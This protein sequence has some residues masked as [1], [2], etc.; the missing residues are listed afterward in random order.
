MA[1][2][3]DTIEALIEKPLDLSRLLDTV[4][5]KTS[6]KFIDHENITIQYLNPSG[7]IKGAHVFGILPNTSAQRLL[8]KFR[9]E[10]NGNIQYQKVLLKPNGSFYMFDEWRPI[11][12][13][14]SRA[15]STNRSPFTKKPT[16]ASWG[17]GKRKYKHKRTRRGK[18]RT[19][20][21]R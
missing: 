19:T 3:T 17:G 2:Y 14:N 9:K 12:T 16:Q 8:G 11:V 18:R 21:K 4:Y 5:E 7:T 13:I 6:S 1:E 15:L 10:E 20:R